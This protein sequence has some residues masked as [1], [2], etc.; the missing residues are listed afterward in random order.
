MQWNHIQLPDPEIQTLSESLNISKILASL[1]LRL[2]I[3]NPNKAQRF[4][5]PRLAHLQDPYELTNMDRAVQRTISAIKN[6][7]SVT[8]LGDYDV[9]GIT[10]TTL[11]TYVLKTF[12]L[13]PHFVTPLRLEEGYG[14]TQ[15]VLERAL[16]DSHPGLLFALDCGTNS[17][18]EVAFLKNKG[19]DVIVIDHHQSKADQTLSR[20]TILINP[21]VYDD[22][23]APWLNLCTVGLVF[24]FTHA[25][26]KNFKETDHPKA[27]AID[28][29]ELLDLVAL[30]TVSDLVPLLEEN[31]I[32]TYYGLQKIQHSNRPGIQAL[33]KVSGLNQSQPLKPSDISFR[34]GP[35]INACGRLSDAALPVNML[36]TDDFQKCTLAA[37]QLNALNQERQEIERS[38]TNHALELVETQG[39]AKQNAIISFSPDWH[40]GVVG[41]VAGK[42]SRIH[43]R[44][45]FILTQEGESAKGSGRS[46]PGINLMTALSEC[47]DLLESWGGHPMAAGITL[48]PTKI[49]EFIDQ[50][51]KVISSQLDALTYLEPPLEISEYLSAEDLT[52]GLLEEIELL[53]PFGMHNPEPIFGIRNAIIPFPVTI[54][55]E[56][57]FRFQI[58]K[59][60]GLPINGIAWKMASNI[61]PHNVPLSLAV[62]FSFNYWNGRKTPQ[63][64]LIDWKLPQN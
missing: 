30:G 64:E 48:N 63:L 18:D 11:L 14:M 57:H 10:S 50:F 25:L 31:R 44:P 28:L 43:N 53:H 42:L 52:E 58:K 54:F 26:I 46:I 7:E 23:E 33:N 20:D 2:G 27:N 16:S 1:L 40:S 21:H 6:H 5:Y 36:L 56:E 19:I 51:N 22:P 59:S 47:S 34:L 15:A 17:V 41:I 61:P 4:L 62:K 37:Q 9:D 13:N 24:K 45:T 29:K 35:R 39:L 32:L 3:S 49:S 8:I 12:G 38:V 55:S 60:S